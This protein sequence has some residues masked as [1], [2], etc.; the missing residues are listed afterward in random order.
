MALGLYAAAR[1]YGLHF[2]PLARERYDLIFHA[3]RRDHPPLAAV[4]ALLRTAEFRA[5]VNEL[6]GYDTQHTGEEMG[7]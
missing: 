6:G 1:A 7:V 5:V 4:L 2:V 3:A